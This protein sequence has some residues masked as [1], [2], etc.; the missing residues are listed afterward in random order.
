MK[1]ILNA[2]LI[3]FGIIFQE[4]FVSALTAAKM[5]LGKMYF[6]IKMILMINVKFPLKIVF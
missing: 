1:T 5:L 3:H 6:L 4:N 2:K